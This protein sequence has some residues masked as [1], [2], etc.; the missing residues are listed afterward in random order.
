[1]KIFRHS[2]AGGNPGDLYRFRTKCGMTGGRCGMTKGRCG[3][4]KKRGFTLLEVVVVI[5]ILSVLMGV[6]ISA[7]APFKERREVLS[8]VKNMASLLKQVQVK[9]SAVEIPS[10]CDA[11]GVGE[12][13]VGFSGSVATLEVVRPGGGACVSSSE[14]LSFSSGSEFVSEGSVVFKTP[15]GSA[16]PVTIGISNY[17]IQ[18][19]L[20]VGEN[21][22]V[23]EPKK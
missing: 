10:A 22:N 8:D 14:V 21:G 15:F 19:D 4:T 9:A 16:S 3:M 2:R 17:G 12:F 5:G 1:M 23:S 18:Y 20:E 7:I 6:G 13:V 11:T